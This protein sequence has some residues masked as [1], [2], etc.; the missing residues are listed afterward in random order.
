MLGG[1]VITESELKTHLMNLCGN[2]WHLAMDDEFG[3][4]FACPNG[5]K[6]ALIRFKNDKKYNSDTLSNEIYPSDD[7]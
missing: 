7:F 1:T 5:Y 4:V 6:A 2:S 3:D